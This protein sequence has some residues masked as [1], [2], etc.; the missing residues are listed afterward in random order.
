MSP[1]R[2]Q[3]AGRR[4]AD[5]LRA[6]EMCEDAE[7]LYQVHDTNDLSAHCFYRDCARDIIRG[8]FS[9]LD[10]ETSHGPAQCGLTICDILD[11]GLRNVIEEGLVYLT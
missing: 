8:I 6:M 4:A 9:K 5:L 2:Q 7:L 11:V 3:V 1:V 10:D